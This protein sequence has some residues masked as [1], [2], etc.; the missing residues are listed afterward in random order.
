MDDASV[1]TRS[2][3]CGSSRLVSAK[4][5]RWLVP[6]CSSKPSAVRASGTA[7][8]PALLTSTSRSPVHPAANDRT[9]DRSARS[10][11]RTSTCPVSPAAAC[12][13]RAGSRTAST[14]RAPAAASARAVA[15][16]SPLLPPV[17]TTV[18]PVCAG[19]SAVLHEVMTTNVGTSAA[20]ARQTVPVIELDADLADLPLV[21]HHCH[22]LVRRDLDRREFEAMLTEAEGPSVLGGSLFDSQIGFAVRRWCAPVLDLPAHAPADDYLTRRAELGAEEVNRRLLAATG[23]Q[24]FLVD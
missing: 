9:E 14:T 10:S 23:T 4:W 22:G 17:I 11:C 5:P 6:N 3:T 1:T 12:S 7:M 20:S 13:P 2:V 18:R 16:P 19:M 24:T 15:R 8:I 21:D